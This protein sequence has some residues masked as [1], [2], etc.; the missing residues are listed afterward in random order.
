MGVLTTIMGFFG[1]GIGITIGLIIGY[2]MFIYFQP[3]DVKVNFSSLFHLYI[4]FSNFICLVNISY[5]Q[6]LF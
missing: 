6:C 2:Y 3:T 4:L 1:F 5:G